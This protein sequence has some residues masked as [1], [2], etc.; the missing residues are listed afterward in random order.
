MAI[1]L[2][3]VYTQDLTESNYKIVGIGI[4]RNSDSAGIFAVNYTTLQQSKDNLIN[5][6]LTKR[7]E[8]IMQPE[9]GC[10][11]HE[12]L[13]EPM[14]REVIRDRVIDSIET[15]VALWLPHIAIKSIDVDVDDLTVDNNRINV[16][17]I[18]NLKVNQNISDSVQ[19]TINQ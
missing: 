13:F 3:R 15:A 1:E 7:G 10:G 4:N 9:F 16:S 8:R 14:S 18:F 17:I 12:I 11:I 6:I 19:I 5:L 2:G